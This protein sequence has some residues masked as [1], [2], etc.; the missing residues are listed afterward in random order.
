MLINI[1]RG[2]RSKVFEQLAPNSDYRDKMVKKQK[3]Q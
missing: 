2:L 3:P 1:K